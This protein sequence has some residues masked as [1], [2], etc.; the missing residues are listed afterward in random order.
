MGNRLYKI[1]KLAHCVQIVF[2]SGV[3]VGPDDILAAI[4][5][6]NELY[7]IKDRLSL[8][9]F[10]GCQATPDFGF[11]AMNRVVDRIR[12]KYGH[13]TPTN[14][15]ALVVEGSTEY[16]LS[17]MFQMLMDGFPTQIGV[18]LDETAARDWI[19]RQ[20]RSEEKSP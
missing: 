13:A 14:R 19:G 20:G 11:N 1:D 3:V 16:G 2:K 15:T 7:S 5:H 10:R 17:R 9:D 12:R 6:E 8:W 18:F 4:E